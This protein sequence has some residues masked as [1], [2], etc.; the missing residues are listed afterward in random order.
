MIIHPKRHFVNPF[1]KKKLNFFRKRLTDWTFQVTI[2]GRRGDKPW[3]LFK[4]LIGRY[5]IL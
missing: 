2:I 4:A 1:F 3:I 5:F